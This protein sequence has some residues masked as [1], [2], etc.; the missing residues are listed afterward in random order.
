MGSVWLSKANE[1]RRSRPGTPQAGPRGKV[2]RSCSVV[3]V[4]LRCRVMLLE[5]SADAVIGS[6]TIVDEDRDLV[7]NK[8]GATRLGFALLSE[9]LGAG[10]AVPVHG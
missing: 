10:G 7:A 8:A 4:V 5:W 9:V 3:R 2:A 1:V 6:R